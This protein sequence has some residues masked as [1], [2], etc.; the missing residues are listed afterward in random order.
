MT[1]V[2]TLFSF[3]LL[4][5]GICLTN[6]SAQNNLDVS[7]QNGAGVPDFLNICGDEDTEVVSITLDGTSTDSRTS[8]TAVAHLF[9]GV[10]FVSFDATNSTPGVNPPNLSDPSNPVFT[11]LPSMQPGGLEEIIIAFS[12]KANCEYIDTINANNAASVFDT[13]EFTYDL[14]PSLGLNE[15]DAN[16]EYRDAFAVPNF[17]ASMNNVFGKGKVGDCFT[18]EIELT[19]SGLDGFIDTMIYENTQ[20]AG[21]WVQSV[22]VNGLPLTLTKTLVGVDTLIQ[23]V[24]D[25]AFFIPNTLGGGAGNGNQFFDPD[26]TAT[27]VENIC[28]VS[29]SGS[30]ASIHDMS[31]GCGGVYCQ[32]TSVTDF[33]EVGQGAANIIT[34]LDANASLP[35]QYAGYCQTG[36]STITIVNDGVEIDPGFATMLNIEAGIGL[37][38]MFEALDGGF[39]ISTVVFAGVTLASPT[40]LV[41]LDGNAQFMTDPDGPGG[42][43]DYDGDGFF[44]DLLL[45]DSIEITAYYDFD[46]STAQELGDDETCRN[47]FRTS[48]SARVSYDDAC[49]V[50]V[51]SQDNNYL[52]P[53]NT[54]S[55]E[56]NF[57]TADAFALLDTFYITHTETRSVRFF[58]KNCGGNEQFM[59]TVVLPSGVNPITSETQIIRNGGTFYS[60]SGSSMSNDTLTLIFDASASPFTN[61]DYEVI[62][63]FQS[64][65][66]ATLGPTVFPMEFAHYCPGCDCK[67]IW[68]CSELT[69]PYLHSTDPP[70]PPV[71]CDPGIRTTSFEVNRT[72]IGYTDN[73]YTTK[74][75][76]D[77][78][79]TKVAISCDSIEMK[80]LNVVGETP[81]TDSIGMV[82]TYSNIDE[83]YDSTETFLF[84]YGNLRIVTGGTEYTCTFDT[85]TMSIEYIDTLKI[86]TFDLNECL[87]NLGG[88][89]L[90]LTSGDTIEYIGN[91]TVNPDGPYPVQFRTVPDLRAEGF[92][93]IDDVDYTCDNFGDILTIAKNLTV[94]NFPTSNNHPKG[95]AQTFL[96]YQL[97]TINNGFA[98]WF[99]TE[100]RQA[101]K[102]DSISFDFDPNILTGFDLF[103]PEVSIPDHPVFGNAFFP[104][105][106]FETTPSGH[107]VARF[108]TL[109]DVPSLNT[110]LPYSFNFR[111]VVIPN[112]Q[113]ETSSENGTPNYQ[114]DSRIFFNDR[115]YA[116]VIGDGSCSTAQK[117]SVINDLA[118][119]DPPTFNFVSNSNPNVS[120]V[121]DTAVWIVQYCNSSFSADAGVTWVALEDSTNTIQVVSMEEISDPANEISLTVVPYGTGNYFGIAPGLDKADGSATLSEICN[122]VRIKALVNNC[123]T[124]NFHTSVGWNCAPYSDPFW[125]PEDYPPCNDLTLQHSVTNLDPL[126][127]ANIIAQDNNPNICDTITIDV[128]LRNTDQGRVYDLVSQ[129]ILPPLGATLATGGISFAYPSGAA[130]LPVATDP[131]YIGTNLQGDIYQ[132]GG[133][134]DLNSY[135]DVEGFPGFNATNP[136]DSNELVI[137]YKFITDCN[138]ISGSL[139]YYNFQGLMG[140]GDS[141]NFET[142]ESLPIQLAGTAIIP[143]K[144]FDVFFDN[145]STLLPGESSDITISVINTETAPTDTVD[146][147]TLRLP[148]E[149]NY[150]D[151][152][153]IAITPNTWTIEAPELDTVS[154]FQ[155]IV[156]CLPT[157]LLQG[158]TASFSFE[159]TS[160]DYSCDTTI[161][162]VELFTLARIPVFCDDLGTNCDVETVTSSNIGNFTDLNVLQDFIDVASSNPTPCA[163]EVVTL[164]ANGA[165]TYIWT[166]S[167][168]GLNIGNTPSV[169]VA[170][171][172]TTTYIVSG[173]DNVT[174]CTAI[175]SIVI[176]INAGTAMAS[177]TAN[178]TQYCQGDTIVLTGGTGVALEWFVGLTSIG[179]GPTI[180]ISA[181]NT[182][183]YGLAVQ[184]AQGCRDT[185]YLTVGVD[186][187]PILVNPVTD[188][189]NCNGTTFPISLQINQNIQSYTISGNFANDVAAGNTLN[190]NAIYNTDTTFFD[191]V[192]FGDLDGCSVT[193]S[194]LILPCPCQ[195][196]EI[197]T[198]AVVGATCGNNDGSAII[199]LNEDESL[200]T[201]SWTPGNLN[202]DTQTGLSF[203]GYTVDIANTI[204]P[205]CNTTAYVAI[206]NAD[207][208]IA[209]AVTTPATCMASDGCATLMP[210]TFTY[211]WADGTIANNRCDLPTGT[212]FAT[213][214]DPANPACQNVIAVLI[215]EE[216]PLEATMNTVTAPDCGVANGEVNIVV[217]GGSGSYNF[218]WQDGTNLTT[219]TRTG[220]T[221]GVYNVT[222]SENSADGCEL[223]FIFVLIDNVPPGLV[224]ISDTMDVTCRG[225]TDGSINYNVTYDGGFTAPADITFTNGFTEFTN[226][227]LPPGAYCIVINDGNG[228]VAGGGCFTIEEPDPISLLYVMSPACEVPVTVDVTASGGSA[229]YNFDWLDITPNPGIDPEDRIDLMAGTDYFITV[230]DANNCTL[231]DDVVASPCTECIQ[232]TLNSVIIMEADCGE[233]DGM[234][235]IGLFEEETN[236]SFTWSPGGLTGNTQTD[237]PAGLYTVLV[238]S[239]Q[240]ANCEMEVNVLITTE[241]GPE[242]TYQTLP[243]ICQAGDGVAVLTPANFDYTWPT[244][245]NPVTNVRNDLAAGTYT[246]TIEDPVNPGCLNVIEVLIEE[247]NPMYATTEVVTAPDCGIANG[248]I[249]VHPLGGS[250]SYTFYWNDPAVPSTDSTQ[251]NLAAGTYVVTIEDNNVATG[252]TI[253]YVFT[254]IDNIGSTTVSIIDTIASACFEENNGSILFDVVYDGTF[255]GPADTIITSG[256][257][258]FENGSLPAGSYC[259]QINDANGCIAA[260]ACF[261]LHDP[262][263]MELLFVVTEDCGGNG[264]ITTTV[265]GGTP[266]FNY[267][268]AHISPSTSDSKDL[269][270]LTIGNYDL[271]VT[272]ANGCT[273][274][275]TEVFVL[276]CIDP[277]NL[278]NG[279]DSAWL[280]M[281]VCGGELVLCL[282]LPIQDI[283]LL[284]ITDNGLPYT[285]GFEGCA[286]DTIHA[287]NYVDLF[288]QGAQGPYDLISWSVDGTIFSGEF[289]DVNALVDSMN[290]WDPLG[291]WGFASVGQIISGGANGSNYGSMEIIALI[292]NPPLTSFLG[293]SFL[294]EPSGFGIVLDEGTHEIII[295]DTINNCTDTL[296][297]TALCSTL[298]TIYTQ[299]IVETTDTLCIDFDDLVGALDTIYNFCEQGDN[300]TV[301]VIPGTNCIEIIGD[302]IGQDI[303]CIVA[304]DVLGICDTVIVIIDV[305]PPYDAVYGGDCINTNITHCI[306]TSTVQVT[307]N[308]VSM[309]NLC[310]E[311]SGESVLF[312]I[313]L[314]NY[315]VRYKGISP[316][317][318]TACIQ[319]CD[320]MGICDTFTYYIT[321]QD[322][323]ITSTVLCDTVYVFHTDTFCLDLSELAGNPV[324]IESVC[325][326]A[327]FGDVDFYLDPINYCVNFTGIF[328]GQDT[329]CIVVCDEFGICDTTFF[330]IFV[331]VFD[332]GPFATFD[333]D[334]TFIGTP[335]VLDVIAND[336]LWG[337]KD[338]LV[339][340]EQ[341]SYGT[342]TV[343]LD[344]SVTYN[345]GDEYCERWDYFVYEVCNVN[346]CDTALV[347]V[348]I[349]CVDIVIFTAVS[350]NGDNQN[351]FFH[352]AGILDFPDNELTILNR[353]GNEVY[354]TRS[355][356]NKWAGTYNNNKELP[357]GTY[358]YL[359]KLNDDAGRV[360]QGF[361]E[362]H[363]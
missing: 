56:E 195:S 125:N 173:T 176:D 86:L 306:D 92:A 355:Y 147:V 6:L 93:T 301:T 265:V 12:V 282:G 275:E 343:N 236:Y 259:L 140:C 21:I 55:T 234:A 219:G 336:T 148:L 192:I 300:A 260:S 1:K 164:T 76:S 4:F 359:L 155:Y 109:L 66:S 84:D 264:S 345:P 127:D 293:V 134:S 34:L 274:Q 135:L 245:G 166:N 222:I 223:P 312:E 315:C 316:G 206:I 218:T 103:Q 120:L 341:P 39:E 335:I 163:G 133:F 285:G 212:H 104:V 89:G 227:N 98:D 256:L 27:I 71:I 51:T 182:T 174:G 130:F 47:D 35:D 207:G 7:F 240:V 74:F 79:N 281:E 233:N 261:E 216:N 289:P 231:E 342:A 262:E 107:Y 209:T 347:K 291:G 228:C 266:A 235:I 311:P 105:A 73:K 170:P 337:G 106:G 239:N 330:C 217:N 157:G 363:R 189:S 255:V 248:T 263:P 36:N 58:E 250:G 72:T 20:G 32:T 43:S 322:C 88:G 304:C 139:S 253:E 276:A 44:D 229:P 331:E 33:I 186:P 100:V 19:S 243:A 122:I 278:F 349:E 294:A 320:A 138:F 69:G 252:C 178:A 257:Q 132:F 346:G 221:A 323:G 26:E 158:D 226:G 160:P 246:V 296:F 313:D 314:D 90:T 196:P 185:A 238:S 172:T 308:I 287:Y 8:I 211:T 321:T 102:I 65:C 194:F 156:W 317:P 224:V 353:W 318:D 188:L 288:G 110:V 284:I 339:I 94:F 199:H 24:L 17:T 11:N 303:A 361:L 143:P 16:S 167:S 319:L 205:G 3:S 113:S 152:S 271:L 183:T 290:I 362:L 360:F 10:Q 64:D 161:I 324:S 45:G 187:S 25:S 184:N 144:L 270:N 350:P 114:L 356:Q 295:G 116:S 354:N 204:T 305:V 40:A 165:T 297:V 123:G 171:T 54:R 131:V 180:S 2:N 191:V 292:N 111:I 332:G 241:G 198:I 286:F 14:G 277:C 254:L 78:A 344:C 142:G 220:L 28:M 154:G 63:A 68:Y 49:T 193:E 190:F 175:D 13:W 351:D 95:C 325:S 244:A 50:R 302:E 99:G 46:C 348:Y 59:V 169:D 310:L 203:G 168:T 118:Y 101:V 215:G 242:A 91:F 129:I 37:G 269:T 214:T 146:K 9:E 108:D 80:I 197:V 358:Y 249:T 70:C 237:L 258:I 268:W 225:A 251:T 81:I 67:H 31:W 115:Y 61:G 5:F 97:V 230:T 149:I 96:N 126:L 136:T 267:D 145:N 273:I 141:T 128:L 202:G 283:S 15:S 153:T 208:P 298:D 23:G 232:P 60:L 299:V 179:S 159:L 326:D 307:G 18:R 137:R 117:D 77:S 38:N 328:T 334:T 181:T 213:I 280:Q 162:P 83:T 309:I 340:L 75:H 57:T 124:T 210:A 329:A 42:L 112:C 279:Q 53:S 52:R 62:M 48:F 357:D 119:T 121:G 201:F 327:S 87:I 177:I 22:T 150:T 151:P 333:C 338:S 247:N 352:I 272:D 30:R 41:T 85:S 82:I 200:Y 29:C